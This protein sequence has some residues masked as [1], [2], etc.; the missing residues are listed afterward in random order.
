MKR[1]NTDAC[2][3]SAI[4]L[5]SVVS[6]IWGA[7]FP[8]TNIAV[9]NGLP[10]ITVATFRILL[11]A[12]VLLALSAITRSSRAH[13]NI[14]NLWRLLPIAL[15]LFSIPYTLMAWSQYYISSSYAVIIL[16]TI[17]L[18]TAG[19]TCLLGQSVRGD[20]TQWQYS[21]VNTFIR[22]LP[23][24]IGV[25]LLMGGPALR[26]DK[27]Q[28]IGCCA[29][30]ATSISCAAA[31]LLM[32]RLPPLPTIFTSTSICIIA[33]FVMTPICLMIDEPWKLLPS[34]TAILALLLL[35]LI[36]TGLSST[37]YMGLTSRYGAVFASL[38]FY[39]S[40][41]SGLFLSTMLLGEEIG[42]YHLAA[43]TLVLISVYL[44]SPPIRLNSLRQAHRTKP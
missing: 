2:G 41:L 22:L 34:P 8:L 38:S 10:P 32:S 16:A 14:E 17:P 6:V 3:A 27:T 24:F 18:I 1:S 29:A 21:A 7:I 20:S 11:A 9:H 15:M 12:V 35:G 31:I 37:L 42:G 19:F 36:C 28:L 4:G 26:S 40:P 30:F 44:I 5:L 23:G 13:L 25:I 33:A 43:I 39:L